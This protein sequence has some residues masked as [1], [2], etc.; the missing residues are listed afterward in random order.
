MR[1]PVRMLVIGA[2]ITALSAPA[3]GQKQ[4]TV[5]DI[6]TCYKEADAA[7][8]APSA[9]P[10]LPDSAPG[11]PGRV[12]DAHGG[13]LADRGPAGRPSA[14][15]GGTVAGPTDSTGQIITNPRDP[16]LEGMA[17]ARASDETYR[18]AYRA[19]MQR[20]GH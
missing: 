11:T 7:V 13:V 5:S 15:S 8:G 14:S 2:T 12:P 9:S 20:L 3:Y 19:C 10:R 17:T 6:A 4:P 1:Q 16:R 18:A